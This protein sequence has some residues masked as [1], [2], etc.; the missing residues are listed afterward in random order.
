MFAGKEQ[1]AKDPRSKNSVLFRD[2]SSLLF[3]FKPTQIQWVFSVCHFRS[4]F[5]KQKLA[6]N[7]ATFWD[8]SKINYCFSNLKDKSTENQCLKKRST[9]NPQKK[10]LRSR[11]NKSKSKVGFLGIYL[12]LWQE[13]NSFFI[14][15]KES[16]EDKNILIWRTL[17]DTF[18]WNLKKKSIHFFKF[19]K[20]PLLNFF[21]T[22]FNDKV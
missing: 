16:F 9:Q 3:F 21:L 14:Y 4:E 6:R 17:L 8:H 12:V 13:F 15:I 18:L 2:L 7:H 11:S 1:I 20:L 10:V 19:L 22:L 5:W